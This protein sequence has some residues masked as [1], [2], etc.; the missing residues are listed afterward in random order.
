MLA[1]TSAL[2]LN[3][4][5]ARR[6]GLVAAQAG[7]A[8][9]GGVHRPVEIGRAAQA[10]MRLHAALLGSNTSPWRSP[11]AKLEPSIQSLM[12]QGVSRPQVW[13]TGVATARPAGARLGSWRQHG[14]LGST[15]TVPLRIVLIHADAG[16]R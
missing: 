15:R 11:E 6:C 1:S 14:Q 12:L 4:T 3:I 2:N 9:L 10:D 8:A 5:R 7:W 13:S 16:R